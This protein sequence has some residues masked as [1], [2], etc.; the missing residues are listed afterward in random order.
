M[1]SSRARSLN[2]AVL[3]P[4]IDNPHYD[5]APFHKRPPLA[6]PDEVSR[7]YAERTDEPPAGADF[8]VEGRVIRYECSLADEAKWRLAAEILLVKSFRSA[9]ARRPTESQPHVRPDTRPLQH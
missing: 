8:E 1:P 5:H 9:R 7:F 4:G 2:S 3:G 6:W